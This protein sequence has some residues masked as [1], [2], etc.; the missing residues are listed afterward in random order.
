LAVKPGKLYGIFVKGALN[1]WD[2]PQLFVMV[3]VPEFGTEIPGPAVT[4]KLPD[5]VYVLFEQAEGFAVMFTPH[6]NE[7]S[8]EPEPP[9]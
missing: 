7:Q 5:K 2:P 1:T 3:S 9:V 6:V 8:A 4:V